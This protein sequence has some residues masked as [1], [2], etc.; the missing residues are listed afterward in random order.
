MT[1]D[2]TMNS[3]SMAQARSGNINLALSCV[4][5]LALLLIAIFAICI[6]HPPE[7][8]QFSSSVVFP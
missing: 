8:S 4:P 1:L 3:S 7:V 5:I 2:R 6:A